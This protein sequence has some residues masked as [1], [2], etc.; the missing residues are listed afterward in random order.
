MTLYKR[1]DVVLVSFTFSD[2][3]G[4]KQRPAVIISSDTYNRTRQETIISA[5][6]SRMERIL[7]G[8]YP[9]NDWKGAGLLVPSVA[10]GIIRTIKQSMIIRKLGTISGDDLKEINK[11]LSIIL[12]I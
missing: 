3:T 11:Q 9:I 8:D 4:T 1:G 10:T 12:G 2:E 6:T 5:I 7:T